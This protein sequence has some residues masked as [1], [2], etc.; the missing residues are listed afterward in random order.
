MHPYLRLCFAYCAIFPKGH[1]IVK[2][3]L[4]HQWI[5]LG[6]IEPSNIFSNRQVS[7]HYI[8]QLLGMSFL[9]HSEL[10]MVSYYL[11]YHFSLCLSNIVILNFFGQLALVL[12]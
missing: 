4:I 10:P 9:Q 6:F 12:V 2:E 11:M 3:D 8:S 5:S 7:E 1:K